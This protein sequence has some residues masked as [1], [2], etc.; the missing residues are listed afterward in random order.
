MLGAHTLAYWDLSDCDPD[1]IA[2]LHAAIEA[3]QEDEVQVQLTRNGPWH[4]QTTGPYKPTACGLVVQRPAAMGS[5]GFK[6]GFKFTFSALTLPL[7]VS[8][9]RLMIASPPAL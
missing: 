2:D 9:L 4:R 3:D 5:V 1:E 7:K 6:P 8:P